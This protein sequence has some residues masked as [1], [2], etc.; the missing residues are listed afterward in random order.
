MLPES[1]LLPQGIRRHRD[2]EKGFGSG[3]A[4]WEKLG[5]P[6]E[7][8][9]GQADPSDK[10]LKGDGGIGKVV[11]HAAE[12]VD[13]LAAPTRGEGKGIPGRSAVDGQELLP[14]SPQVYRKKAEQP[15]AVRRGVVA[16]HVP[17][18]YAAVVVVPMAVPVQLHVGER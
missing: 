12:V 10:F 11:C 14:V 2:H 9:R 6:G 17:V 16:R 8:G 1:R 5:N 4:G 7:R 18:K 15:G 3:D 13:K